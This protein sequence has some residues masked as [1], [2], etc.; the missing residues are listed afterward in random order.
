MNTLTSIEPVSS[1][2]AAVGIAPLQFALR[3]VQSGQP[4]RTMPLASGKCTV[5][6]SSRCQVQLASP[7]V[8]PLH[9]LLVHEGEETTVTRWAAG[10]LL[11]GQ[12]FTTTTFCPGDCLQI[13]DVEVTLVA[14]SVPEGVPEIT[15][16]KQTP[17]S[18]PEKLVQAETTAIEEIIDEIAEEVSEEL[19]VVEKV[20][21]PAK[22]RPVSGLAS[23]P[24]MADPTMSAANAL[25]SDRLVRQLWSANYGARQRCRKL[26]RSLRDVRTEASNFDQQLDILQEQL[27]KTLAEREQVS[28]ELNQLQSESTSREEQVAEELDR[29]ISELSVAYEKSSEAEAAST[30]HVQI[31]DELRGELETLYA[32]REQLQADFERALAATEAA[33]AQGAEQSEVNN[34]LQA[35]LE[36]IQLQKNELEETIAEF[37]HY[38]PEWESAVS[39]RDQRIGELLR[40]MEQ[41]HGTILTLEES[42]VEQTARIEHLQSELGQAQAATVSGDQQVADHVANAARIQ[43]ELSLLRQERD[44]LLGS[45]TKHSEDQKQ[46]EQSLAERDRRIEELQIE[47]KGVCETLETFEQGAFEQIDACKRLEEKLA[48]VCEQRDQI[49]L[50]QAER[51]QQS[52]QLEETLQCRDRQIAELSEELGT[53]AQGRGELQSELEG[54]KSAAEQLE[55]EV[56]KLRAR[57]E[58]SSSD[59][60]SSEQRYAEIQQAFSGQQEELEQVRQQLEAAHQQKETLESTLAERIATCEIFESGQADLHTRCEQLAADHATESE[61]CQELGSNLAQR[62]QSIML[63]EADLKSVRAELQRSVDRT[64]QLEGKCDAAESQLA[65]LQEELEAKDAHLIDAG[66]VDSTWQQERDDL[67]RTLEATQQELAEARE[68]GSACRRGRRRSRCLRVNSAS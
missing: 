26:V 58:D 54:Q 24:A 5:G 64:Q 48:E 63:F 4:E 27:R 40:E 57:C 50:V 56:L 39:E 1:V 67:V 52:Q 68:C 22:P 11:N 45:Q 44:Q 66:E 13:G 16:D 6:S 2:S 10:A 31:G 60:D 30:A 15:A 7:Q 41:I 8:R 21:A 3:I 37:Q 51:E 43:E 62:Q 53:L 12:D 18:P 55:S 17:P 42:D 46:W 47:H 9:C 14:E 65:A 32:E 20:V 23:R 19:E 36:K 34:Q 25:E 59:F 29:L 33:A 28:G 61:R 49:A 38:Q 35:D